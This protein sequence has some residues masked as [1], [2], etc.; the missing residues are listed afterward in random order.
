MNYLQMNDTWLGAPGQAHAP[1]SMT[2]LPS[3][4]E[5]RLVQ[6]AVRE[7]LM[8]FPSEVPVFE[9]QSRPDL[10][11]KLAVLYFVRGWTMDDIA[12]RYGLVR[13]RMG[14]ILTAWRVR[15]MN[16]G[17]IQPIAPEHPLLKRARSRKANQFTEASVPVNIAVT[18]ADEMA[19]EPKIAA[20]ASEAGAPLVTDSG[21]SKSAEELQ[22]IVS[23]LDN[24]LRLGSRP[25]Y[26]SIDSC[27]LLLDRAKALCARLEAQRPAAGGNGEPP[28]LNIVSAA[29]NLFRRFEEQAAEQSVLTFGHSGFGT[30]RHESEIAFRGR[31]RSR[32]P[33]VINPRRSKSAQ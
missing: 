15:A 31:T 13:Q 4:L 16:E 30:S 29:K 20:P 19:R 8:S 5:N 33:S 23:I 18:D 7:N 6:Q 17:Y 25:L 12:R 21:Q 9:R 14:Q 28:T 2:I 11:Q 10:Q 26:R 32:G 27:E 1:R 3:D 22:V 24:Q